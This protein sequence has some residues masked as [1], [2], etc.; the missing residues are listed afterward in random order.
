MTV[1]CFSPVNYIASGFWGIL[2]IYF[3]ACF[4]KFDY[5]MPTEMENDSSE[6]VGSEEETLPSE[7]L[8]SE[9]LPAKKLPL[10]RQESTIVLEKGDNLIGRTSEGIPIR[11]M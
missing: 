5:E 11:L 8:P 7:T 4:K 10:E 6:T 2:G 3:G 9:K 1:A